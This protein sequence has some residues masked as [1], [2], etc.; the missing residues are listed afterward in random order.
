MTVKEFPLVTWNPIQYIRMK[1]C[2]QKR[3]SYNHSLTVQHLFVSLWNS[4]VPRSV[5]LQY[6]P[7]PGELVLT[8]PGLLSYVLYSCMSE[9][10]AELIAHFYPPFKL[11]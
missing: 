11:I 6:H 10:K 7:D 9:Y 3:V 4:P 2:Y 8:L 1:R 5:G